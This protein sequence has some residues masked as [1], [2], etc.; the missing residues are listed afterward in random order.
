MRS[1]SACPTDPA[2][3]TFGWKHVAKLL[4][5]PSTESVS[6]TGPAA[7][8]HYSAFP[9]PLPPLAVR[10]C[11]LF[12]RDAGP[13]L[14]A[15]LHRAALD[16]VAV[17]P[18]GV[19]AHVSQPSHLHI[20]VFMGSQPH[21]LRPDPA[22][23]DGGILAE[24]ADPA[25][26]APS[27]A[28]LAAEIELMR[29]EANAVAPPSLRVHRILMADSGTLLLCCVDG[30]GRLASLRAALR[31]RLPGAP[32]RQSTIAHASLARVLT[33]SQFDSTTRARIKEVCDRCTTEL[34]GMEVPTFKLYHVCEEQFT[35]VE[36]P[37]VAL[38]FSSKG[39]EAQNWV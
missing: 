10:L 4:L 25:A 24:G 8:L 9:S 3:P 29:Q 13:A 38:P 21:A 33:T 28:V 23:P 17:L 32:P 18:M 35:T 31:R 14:V 37:S 15:A 7:P 27:P 22:S 1:S 19:K 30:S 39:S 11:V 16:V 2:A 36:G 12:L 6:L 5:T 26:G 34:R 20:T